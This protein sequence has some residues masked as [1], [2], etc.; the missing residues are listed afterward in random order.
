M[1]QLD[2]G[3]TIIGTEII[4]LLA[5]GSSNLA[6]EQYVNT[7][8]AN[9]GV[10]GGTGTTDLTNYY[11]KTETDAL[12]NNKYN[13][14]EADTLLDTKLNVNNPQNMEGTLNIGSVG[15]TSKIIINAVSS[16]ND[17]YVNG[18]AQVLGN[19]LVASLDSSG[20][21]KGSNIQS[22]TFNALNLNDILFQSNN[23]TYIQYDVS[24]TKI[25][26]SKLIQCGGNPKTQ[27]ID[28]I[29]PLDLV[30]KR[31]GV[32][33]ITLA[34]GQIQFNQPTNLSITPD[35]SDCVKLTGEAS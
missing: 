7:A 17:F 6:T 15:G 35:L 32:D 24:E 27:E 28:T 8:V 10:G 4:K 11:N 19:H 31:G 29:A 1:V 34:D 13:K 5:T 22:N 14:T 20:Y 21:I 26:A 9:G 12:L 33:Y 3:N 30:I 23:D 16:S 2:G 25:V 18:D